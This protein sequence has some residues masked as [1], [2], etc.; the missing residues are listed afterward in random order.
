VSVELKFDAE[1][2]REVIRRHGEVYQKL[3]DEGSGF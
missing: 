2:M 3:H 1:S